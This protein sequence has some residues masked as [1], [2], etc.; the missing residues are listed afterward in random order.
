MTTSISRKISEI[1]RKIYGR[2]KGNKIMDEQTDKASY[3]ANS[4]SYNHS[5]LKRKKTQNFSINMK[6]Y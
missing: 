6:Y 4:V 5:I 2:K 1:I 3:R